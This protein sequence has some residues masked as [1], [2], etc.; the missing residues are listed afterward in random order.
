MPRDG[1]GVY[2]LPAGNPVATG[3][4]IASTWANNTL[5]D[6]AT[7]LNNVYTRDGVAGPTSAFKVADGSISAPGLAW[8]SQPDLGWYRQGSGKLLFVTG[9]SG[10]HVIDNTGSGTVENLHPRTFTG[11]SMLRLNTALYGDVFGQVLALSASTPNGLKIESLV[12]GAATKLD[13]Q[14]DSTQFKGRAYT[15][16]VSVTISATPTF[17]AKASNVFYLGDMS[18]SVTSF[19]ITNPADGQTINIR[20]KQDSVGNKTVD[21]PANVKA[22]GSIDPTANRASWL[23]LT[24]VGLVSRWEGAWS[25]VG[26]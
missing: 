25:W 26:A 5:S 20:F 15:A 16:P 9:G 23:V 1:S 19:T 11:T 2:T 8:N 13:I 4:V 18:I 14:I 10:T 3:T 7:Q 12:L 6:I 17:D 22:S 21:F 24:Y